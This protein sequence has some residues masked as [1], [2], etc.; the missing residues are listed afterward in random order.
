MSG[1][2]IRVMLLGAGTAAQAAA[3]GTVVDGAQTCLKI[4]EGELRTRRL[5][6]QKHVIR[7]FG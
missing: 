4:S 3:Q 7:G 1:A 2:H 6:D 5:G